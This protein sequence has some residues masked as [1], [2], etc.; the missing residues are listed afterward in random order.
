M[1]RREEL[2]SA[3]SDLAT[4]YH[5]TFGLDLPPLNHEILLY[6]YILSLGLPLEIF[7]SVQ[8]LAQATQSR[9]C[10]S[11]SKGTRRKQGFAFPELQ[12]MSLLVIS[13]KLL[14]P[15]DNLQRH[16][17]SAIEPV[18]QQ[19]DW[20]S[21]K[22][23]RENSAK[24]PSEAGLAKG[25][26]IDVCDTDVFNMRQQDLDSYMEWYQK[27]WVGKPRPGS[28][29]SVNKEILDMFPLASLDS[30]LQQ[31]SSQREKEL[32]QIATQNTRATVASVRFQR[33]V[34]D[35]ETTDESV[36]VK[37]PGEEY[38]SYKT[39]QDLPATAMAFFL[40][41]SEIACTS[42]KNLLLAVLQAEA[43]VTKWKRAK[44][45]ADVT[46]E[47][48]DLDAELGNDADER[49]ESKMQQ[50]ME[51]MRIQDSADESEG[52]R[53]EGGGEDSDGDMQMIS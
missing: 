17:C 24:R 49:L 1:L 40:A 35:E 25:S 6:K 7:P 42:V 43:K 41:A 11:T 22:Q 12:L 53:G 13:I 19:I 48:F 30:V 2:H 38:R 18:A 29:D 21:W 46:G 36:D 8:R 50:E 28:D 10:Y 27:T 26:E 20:E 14:Y 9:F 34:T 51:A 32:E 52:G 33:P 15:F 3:V 31:P 16:P 4:M 39:E 44:R 37:R 23:R 47:E 45:R 5:Q